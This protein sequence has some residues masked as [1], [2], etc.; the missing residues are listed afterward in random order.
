MAASPAFLDWLVS[1]ILIVALVVYA[2]DNSWKAGQSWA[3][4][5]DRDV[6]ETIAQKVRDA[7]T[8][9]GDQGVIIAGCLPIER[10]RPA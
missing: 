4:Y 5:A 10:P 2:G 6:C 8:K 3:V 1:W 7:H 9:S